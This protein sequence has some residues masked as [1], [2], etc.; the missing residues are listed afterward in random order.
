MTYNESGFTDYLDLIDEFGEKADAAAAT[1]GSM[2]SN[3][4]QD[5]T[6]RTGLAVAGWTPDRSD[7]NAQAV[8]W[9]GVGEL[10]TSG[11]DEN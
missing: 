7:M 10:I 11:L 6:M 9:W 1:A 4:I 2:L 5:Q 8:E 3:D